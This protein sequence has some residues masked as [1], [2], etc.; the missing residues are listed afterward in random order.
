MEV[1]TYN[2]A[3]KIFEMFDKSRLSGAPKLP[4]RVGTTESG[5]RQRSV[6]PL[7]SNSSSVKYHSFGKTGE[8]TRWF[9]KNVLKTAENC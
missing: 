1:E 8:A 5:V 3:M 2:N 6:H 9:C 7:V 4:R